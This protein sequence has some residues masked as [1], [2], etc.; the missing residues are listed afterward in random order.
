[1]GMV[2][3]RRAGAMAA[4]TAATRP[5]INAAETT[6]IGAWNSIIHPKT[7]LAAFFVGASDA[8]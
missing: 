3:A 8:P 5:D 4:I 6:L 2:A 1:M 7:A